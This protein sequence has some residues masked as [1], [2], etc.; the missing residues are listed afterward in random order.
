MVLADI[1]E[2][3]TREAPI[4]LVAALLS[5][6]AAMWLTLGSLPTAL[7]CLAPTVV[8]ILALAGVMAATGLPF[9]YL[10]ILVVPVLIGVTVDAGV[11]LMTRLSERDADFVSI[12]A[13]TGR[14]IVGGLLTSAVG[15]GAL[16]LADHPGLDSVGRLANLGFLINLIVMLVVF[17][18]MVLLRRKQEQPEVSPR[19]PATAGGR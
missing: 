19:E 7:L 11:H 15:F 10:N 14:A 6:L 3:V 9:N 5:V 2:M 8:S 16:L 1:L 17:P 13:E 4:V 12:Y 18:A